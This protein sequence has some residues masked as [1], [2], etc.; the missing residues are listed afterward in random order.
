MRGHLRGELDER[1]IE[2]GDAAFDGA[3]HAH[4]I[5]LHEQFD[6]IGFLIGVE[7]TRQRIGSAALV[8]V[9]QVF[10][11]GVG[12][13]ARVFYETLLFIGGERR[14]KVIEIQRFDGKFATQEGMLRFAAEI[15]GQQ[16]GASDEMADGL[17]Q[18]LGNF[19]IHGA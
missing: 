7:Q 6:E 5:L 13:G 1:V 4:L 17:A 8:A 10:G 14:I 15:G 3:S 2:E 16:A 9:A 12:G 11:I 18:K 19:A